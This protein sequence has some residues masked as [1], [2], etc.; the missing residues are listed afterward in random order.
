MYGLL[1]QVKILIEDVEFM[2]QTL[3]TRYSKFLKLN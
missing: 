1:N 2:F 3:L